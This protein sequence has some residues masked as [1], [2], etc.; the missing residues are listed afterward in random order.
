M[1]LRRYIEKRNNETR[2]KI[3]ILFFFLS[4]FVFLYEFSNYLLKSISQ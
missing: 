2:I 1:E 4:F 3:D